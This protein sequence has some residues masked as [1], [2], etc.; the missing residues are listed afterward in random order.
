MAQSEFEWERSYRGRT[1]ASPAA[2]IALNR[3]L[4]PWEDGN[5]MLYALNRLAATDKHQI[6]TPIASTSGEASI[7]GIRVK[8]GKPGS[9]LNRVEGQVPWFTEVGEEIAMMS[10]EAGSDAEVTGPIDFAAGFAFGKVDIVARQ[11][12]VTILHQ[13]CGICD[14]VVNLIERAGRENL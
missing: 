10:F 3:A 4:K 13:F 9:G 8:N 1:K 6:L 7:D 5:A 2:V 12:V 11:P 14:N